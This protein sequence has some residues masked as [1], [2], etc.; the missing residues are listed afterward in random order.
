MN[1]QT[2]LHD[3]PE[4]MASI[5]QILNVNIKA[6]LKGTSKKT[7]M[8]EVNRGTYHKAESVGENASKGMGLSVWRGF[9]ITCVPN[10]GKIFLQ[11]DPV[12]RVLSLKS[13]L[14]VLHEEK[15]NRM[16]LE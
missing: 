1:L 10:N 3:N 2:F 12:S 6:N 5:I 16:G 4:D 11:V 13:F 14:E 7:Q 15:S 9:K 8:I